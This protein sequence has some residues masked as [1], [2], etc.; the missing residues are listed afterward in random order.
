MDLINSETGQLRK[1]KTSTR[2]RWWIPRCNMCGLKFQKGMTRYDWRLRQPIGTSY[3]ES[4]T[5]WTTSCRNCLKLTLKA[6]HHTLDEMY[7]AF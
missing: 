3:R 1:L 7:D 2:N 6:W 5:F 4:C